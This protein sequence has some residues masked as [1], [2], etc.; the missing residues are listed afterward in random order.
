LLVEDDS[1]VRES[2]AL[3][4][5]ACGYRTEVAENGQEAL[6]KL[7]DGSPPCMVVTDLRM[8]VM[9]GW[10]LRDEMKKDEGLADLPVVVVSA[11]ATTEIDAERLDAVACLQKPLNIKQLLGVL[12]RY[13]RR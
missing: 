13:C 3:L 5:Q 1:D 2:L 10:E 8:P 12:D 11:N 7:R 6:E 4:L 9:D